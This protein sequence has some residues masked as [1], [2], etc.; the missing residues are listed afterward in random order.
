MKSWINSILPIMPRNLIYCDVGARWGIGETWK[1]FRDILE[2]LRFE[3]DKEEYES[4]M[5]NKGA[6]DMIYQY[7]LY[8][9]PKNV[10]LNLTKSRGCSSLYKPNHDFLRNYADSKRFEIEDVIAVK[11]TSLDTLYKDN[12][13]SNIDFIKIDAQG[14]ELDILKGGETF[15]REHI[16]GIEIEVEFQPL[17]KEQPLFSD[18]DACIRDSLKLQIQDIRKTYWKYPIGIDIGAAKGQLIFGDALYFRSPYEILSWCS[19]FHKKEASDKILMACLMGIVYGY[20][21]YSLCVLNQSSIGDFLDQDMIDSWKSLIFQYGKNLKYNGKGTG[22]MA[23][24]FNYFY[25]ICQPTHEG[26]ASFGHHLG[27]RKKFGVFN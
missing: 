2:L 18:V 1:S 26:W 17:Y 24:L 19:R 21:D 23:A 22:K 25:R 10:S 6:N 12:V 27:T 9:E 13:F 5:K 15:L 14:A 16:A 20:L 4:L 3:P 11:A 7:A 8:K